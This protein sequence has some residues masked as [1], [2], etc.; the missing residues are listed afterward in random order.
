[1]SGSAK[2]DSSTRTAL[3]VGPSRGPVVRA[4][5]RTT[6]SSMMICPIWGMSS[7]GDMEQPPSPGIFLPDPSS[8]PLDMLV[9]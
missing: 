6:G 3:T 9:F 7:R 5:S 4:F 1:M 2:R 8:V